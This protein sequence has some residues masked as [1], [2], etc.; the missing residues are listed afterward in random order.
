[1]TFQGSVYLIMDTKKFREKFN[2]SQRDFSVFFEVPYGTVKNWDA[3]GCVPV[4]FMNL[5]YRFMELFGGVGN[6]KTKDT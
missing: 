6:D 5:C 3:R 1:M 4:Y 2:M